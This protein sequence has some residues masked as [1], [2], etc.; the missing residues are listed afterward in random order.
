MKFLYLILLSTFESI[1]A[2]IVYRSILKPTNTANDNLEIGLVLK[3][4][5]V[6][7]DLPNGFTFCE[8]FNYR[9]LGRYSVL[10]SIG[11]ENGVH[12]DCIWTFVGY[13][14]TFVGLGNF[15]WILKD[16]INDDF[17]PWTT[18]RWHQVCLSFDN[19]D[20][21]LTFVKVVL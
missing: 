6:N 4:E 8:K 2:E 16:P 14:L 19:K 21:K 20:S 7:L 9:V 10:V 13:K 17:L 1:K 18:N 3:K 15:N 5:S 11:C 12:V